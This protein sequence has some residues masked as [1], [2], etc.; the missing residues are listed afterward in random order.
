[1]QWLASWRNTSIASNPAPLT[2]YV[3]SGASLMF[4]VFAKTNAVDN[5]TSFA[6]NPPA[7]YDGGAASQPTGPNVFSVIDGE[8]VP[9]LA[10]SCAWQTWRT[11]SFAN[12][13]SNCTYDASP[14]NMPTNCSITPHGMPGLTAQQA[15]VSP[16]QLTSANVMM[17]KSPVPTDGP[18]GNSWMS[19]TV[20]GG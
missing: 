5:S 9:N 12:A 3:T 19:C 1:M 20:P 8:T 16:M 7:S 2:R 10:R 11:G 13:T 18:S 6:A 14:P 17:L 4:D 15:G